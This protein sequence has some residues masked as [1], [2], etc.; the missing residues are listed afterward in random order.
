M[1]KE[2]K[3]LFFTRVCQNKAV[4]REQQRIQIVST[5]KAAVDAEFG[6]QTGWVAALLV[7]SVRR[8]L[9]EV[10]RMVILFVLYFPC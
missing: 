7:I 9:D 6:E 5:K 2:E 8:V 1:Q 3:W 10:W 4:G